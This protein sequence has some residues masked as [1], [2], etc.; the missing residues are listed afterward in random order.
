MGRNARYVMHHLPLP[1][2]LGGRDTVY[3]SV[4]DYIIPSFKMGCE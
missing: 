3:L 4:S 2:S 1:I